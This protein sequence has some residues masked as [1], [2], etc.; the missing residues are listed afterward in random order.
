MVSELIRLT[1]IFDSSM[2]ASTSSI[3][4]TIPNVTQPISMKLEDSSNYLAWTFQF[5]PVLRSNDLLGIVDG[6]EL[7]PPKH[8]PNVEGQLSSSV[9]PKF[10]LWQKKDQFVLSL[11]NSTLSMSVLSS[12]YGL[13]TARQVWNHLAQRFVSQSCSHVTHLK[14]QLQSLNQGTKTCSEYL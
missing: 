1:P 5:L 9:N 7:C 12:V 4:F 11:L 14:R 3:T 6:S 13:C 2:A 8:L 10:I